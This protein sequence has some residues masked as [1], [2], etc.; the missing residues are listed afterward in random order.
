MVTLARW[1]LAMLRK[2][3][4]CPVPMPPMPITPILTGT[5]GGEEGSWL[6]PPLARSETALQRPAR[7][8]WSRRETRAGNGRSLRY[9]LGL[10]AFQQ[11]E[12]C[13]DTFTFRQ[14]VALVLN[15]D[16]GVEVGGQDDAQEP[17][18]VLGGFVTEGIKVM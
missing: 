17:P 18:V 11:P 5:E 9:Q 12:G 3:S 14:S 7:P 16:P 13:R 2:A 4:T 10:I 6:G 15:P 8:P 1:S